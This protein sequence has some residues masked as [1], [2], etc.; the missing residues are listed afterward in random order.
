MFGGQSIQI[1]RVFGVR[2]GVHPSWFIVF[3]LFIWWLSTYYKDVLPGDNTILPF[4][5]AAASALLFFVSV[6]LHEL[7]HALV[8]KR[9]KIAIAGIDLWLFGGVARMTKDT[10]S[11]GVEFRVAAAGPLVTVVIILICGGLGILLGERSQFVEAIEFKQ[12]ALSQ[13]WLALLA[14]LTTI[15][16]VVL[17]FN[18][19]P[20]Y[21]L[22]GGRIARSIA[23]AI[24]GDRQKATNFAA[25][26]GRGFSFVL[27]GLGLFALI[28]GD[29]IGG[30]WFVFLGLI[31]GQAAKGAQ[32]QSAVSAR[33][34][35]VTVADVM[36]REPVAVPAN[37]DLERARNEYFMRYG[38]EW[39][40]VVDLQG[41]YVGVV[42]LRALNATDPG[43]YGTTLVQDVMQGDQDGSLRVSEQEELENLLGRQDLAKIGALMAVDAAGKLSG[44]IT[45]D[46]IRRTLAGQQAR[47][48]G[49][50]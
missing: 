18:L 48:S 29:V 5:L 28:Q 27:I 8:A 50:T 30:V 9:N 31:L 42:T 43:R 44:V 1:A 38:D 17:I 32:A 16:L 7:G 25:I 6:V 13:W 24:T 39:F 2:I 12:A 22:D 21:P 26:L 35:G 3:F 20:A 46:Q 19:V 49:A 4:V 15:N 47:S 40:P 14:W 37:F 45:V 34:E 10:P 41:R 33:I 36:D 11:A 23:W